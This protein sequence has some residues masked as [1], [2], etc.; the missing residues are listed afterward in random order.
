MGKKPTMEQIERFV[1][2]LGEDAEDNS[3]GKAIEAHRQSTDRN[4]EADQQARKHFGW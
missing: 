4:P 3:T 2:G 1:D